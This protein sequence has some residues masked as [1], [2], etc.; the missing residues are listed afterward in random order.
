MKQKE[1]L[2]WEQL[3]D[4]RDQLKTPLTNRSVLIPFGSR[5]FIPGTLQ[6]T[7]I[8]NNNDEA[9]S[10]SESVE[11]VMDDGISKKKV[12][13]TREQVLE[14]L[15]KEMLN[16]QKSKK[17]ES[18][19]SMS[20][21]SNSTDVTAKHNGDHTITKNLTPNESQATASI[22]ASS[23]IP[24]RQQPEGLKSSL[25]NSTS[26][27]DS[28]YEIR[29]ELDEDGTMKL[30]EAVNITKHLEYLSKQERDG[31]EEKT[32]EDSMDVQ[33]NSQMLSDKEISDIESSPYSLLPKEKPLKPL[34]NDEYTQLSARLEA[35]A[36]LE[37][38][39]D[40][41]KHI[42]AK[43][44]VKLQSSGWKKGFFNT[45][46]NQK[47]KISIKTKTIHKSAS[48]SNQ[49]ANTI[50]DPISVKNDDTHKIVQNNTEMKS[51]ISKN[52][53]EAMMKE[54][55]SI[56]FVEKPL[57]QDQ[58][59]QRRKVAF[60]EERNE[61]QEIP[62]IGERSVKEEV[63][64]RRLPSRPISNNSFFN[65]TK[66]SNET[67]TNETTRYN[68][69]PVSD[70]ASIVQEKKRKPKKK[71]IMIDRIIMQSPQQQQSNN[72]NHEEVIEN[73]SILSEPTT[74]KVSRF[75]QERRMGHSFS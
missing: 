49:N 75:V 74:K 68:A 32:Q 28:F 59:Q 46:N 9:S 72:L 64:N 44:A 19:T 22:T 71:T 27:I 16:K 48:P 51:S 43:S 67:T 54:K 66:P 60:V 38:N 20:S 41:N 14:Y 29:E 18:L 52:T 56:P 45:N 36:L 50:P 21:I 65:S 10:S 2:T 39:T 58:Q 37:D 1:E 63:T 5:A 42:N 12:S 25:K 34:S 23:G 69:L 70:V 24:S 62:R 4:L 47:K 15:Q 73:A 33:S 55:Q 61:T 53:D 26:P 40:K 13:M 57:V 31:N 7:L 6:P 17:V 11:V 3:R 8:T 30:G 35:L